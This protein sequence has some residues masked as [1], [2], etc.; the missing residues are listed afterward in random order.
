MIDLIG[1]WF[2]VSL[3]VVVIIYPFVFLLGIVADYLIDTI[4]EGDHKNIVTQSKFMGLCYSFGET[5]YRGYSYT[6]VATGMTLI[7]SFII[8][9]V[10][11]I[12]T[13]LPCGNPRADHVHS[14]SIVSLVAKISQALAPFLGWVFIVSASVVTFV[15]C[16]KKVYKLGKAVKTLQE[17]CE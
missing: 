12:I 3:L 7:F 4:T 11:N 13:L 15:W 6:G 1:F 5:N 14:D 16:A 9:V 17:K 2:S 8:S 10:F